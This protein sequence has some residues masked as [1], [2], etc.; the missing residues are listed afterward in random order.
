[1]QMRLFITFLLSVLFIQITYAQGF[2]NK[3]LRELQHEN[4]SLENLDE[5]IFLIA[6]LKR[7]AES[8]CLMPLSETSKQ[9]IKSN[10]SEKYKTIIKNLKEGQQ[11]WSYE[12]I[13]KL[14]SIIKVSDEYVRLLQ[15]DIIDQ[16]QES[17]DYQN[18]SKLIIAEA[19]VNT[20]VVPLNEYINKRLTKLYW[21]KRKRLFEK[22][23]TFEE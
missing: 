9:N 7:G 23:A 15:T 21:S 1:M 11:Y 16:F 14:D 19:T 20:K 18:A 10:C 8:W 13:Q 5:L 17:K 3:L 22:L 4:E 6:K 12:E 2:N